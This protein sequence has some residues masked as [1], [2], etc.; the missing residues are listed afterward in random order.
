MDS[1]QEILASLRKPTDKWILTITIILSVLGLLMIFS[2]STVT[3][4]S[5]PEFGYDAF[6]FLKRQAFALMVGLVGMH[7][8][9]KMDLLKLR[10]WSS[11]PFALVTIGLLV[12]VMLVGPKINGARRWLPLGPLQF[13]PAEMAKLAIIFYLADCL[14][15][16]REKIAYFK[17]L[18]PALALFGITLFLVEHEPDL[19]TALVIAGVFMGMLFMAGARMEHLTSMAAAGGV[20]VGVMCILK[21]FRM[22]RLATFVNPMGDIRGD[23]YQLYNSILALASGGV[24]GTGIGGSHQK[25]NYLPEGHTDFIFAIF[26]EELG[27]LGCT[28][29]SALY[30]A[31]L[32]KGFKVAIACRKPYLR[33]IAAGVSFQIA[34]Q[35]LMNMAV[36]SGAIPTTGVPLPFISYG[37]TS[38]MFTLFSVGIILNVADYNATAHLQAAPKGLKHRE[39]K[40][41]TLVHSSDENIS[42]VSSGTWE[43]RAAGQRLVRPKTLLPNPQIEPNLTDGFSTRAQRRFENKKKELQA[44]KRAIL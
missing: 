21:P 22:K 16:R 2:A 9:R 28:G 17:K 33:L 15:R 42:P 39:R 44:K 19:G 38:I 26:G 34:L 40:G 12:L 36:A 4:A 18:I 35:A 27:L 13:Q 30:L 10:P 8:A 14:D 24:W 3:T 31:L 7:F 11:I 20:A 5:S 41:A 25:F 43:Q 29:L 32:F 37:G 1:H 23:G 6:F